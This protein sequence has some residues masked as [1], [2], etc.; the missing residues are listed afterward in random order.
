[1]ED[2]EEKIQTLYA[3]IGSMVSASPED[4]MTS[5]FSMK[6]HPESGDLFMEVTTTTPLA[7]SYEEA[8]TITPGGVQ[9]KESLSNK[10]LIHVSPWVRQQRPTPTPTN[11][12]V[13]VNS[14]DSTGTR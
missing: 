11:P 6:Q 8:L 12:H 3:D 4:A 7:C 13:A 14:T 2:L 1:M 9:L 10:Q 5:H